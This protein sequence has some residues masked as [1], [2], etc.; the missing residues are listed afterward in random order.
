MKKKKRHFQHGPLFKGRH[1]RLSLCMIVKNEAENL[2][3]CIDSLRAIMDEIIVVDT[4][5]T[6]GTKEIARQL[7]VKVFDFPWCDDFSAARNESIKHATGDYILWLDADDRIDESEVQKIKFLK[8]MLSSEKQEA[9]YFFVN[10][11]SPVDGE[12][13]FLQMRV[14]PNI[15]GAVF[16]GRIHEQIFQALA[17]KGIKFVSTDIAVRHTGYH[18]AAVVY[19]KSERN[20]RII[21]EELKSDPDNLLLHYNAARTLAGINRQAEAITHMKRVMENES[22][23]K[24]DAQFFLVTSLLLGKYYSEL[25]FYDEAISIFEELSKDFEGNGL[26]HFCF[27]QILFSAGDYRRSQEELEKSLRSPVEV[28]LFPIDIK[29]LHYYQYYTL[30]QCYT[31]RGEASLAK[32]MFLKSLDLHRDH[33]KSLESLGLL[34][35]KEGGF[36]EAVQYLERAI[37]EGGGSDRNYANVGLAYCKLGLWIEAEKALIKALEINPQRI[38]AL[39]NL[40][41]LYHK[42]KEHPKAMDS[43]IEALGLDPDLKDVRLALSD[44]Y[45]RFYDLENLVQQCDALLSQLDLPRDITLNSFEDLS[46]LYERIGETLSLNGQEDLS[47]MAYHTSLLIYPSQRVLEKIVSKA[48]VLKVMENSIEKIKEILEFHASITPTLPGQGK[49]KVMGQ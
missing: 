33:H 41:H 26:L 44:I 2:A 30:G 35:L 25:R 22:I 29:H 31:E 17:H 23:K 21:E 18:D 46:S 4:G 3:P 15:A 12:T 9:Y 39:T 1:P 49:I 24:D 43:F 8:G 36:E 10:C 37:Q 48:T 19:K 7:G 11:L 20:L 27:G 28:S 34:N 13:S 14:F 42:K 6:D 5:S 16:E 45:F 40:G 38:E 32:E 47:L